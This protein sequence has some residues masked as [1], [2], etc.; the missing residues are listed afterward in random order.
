MQL[1]DKKVVRQ[2][3]LRPHLG[4]RIRGYATQATCGI[5]FKPKCIKNKND[6]WVILPKQGK[7]KPNPITVDLVVAL[8]PVQGKRGQWNV[9]VKEKY[10]KVAEQWLIENCV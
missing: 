10:I 4:R 6:D 9:I 2:F 3:G 8:T 7:F 5:I 1:N